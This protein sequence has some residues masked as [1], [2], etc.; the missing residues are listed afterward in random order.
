MYEYGYTMTSDGESRETVL[1]TCTDNEMPMRR[2]E[3][4]YATQHEA[5]QP[6][7]RGQMCAN[8]AQHWV[9]PASK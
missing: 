3:A 5:T 8:P 7:L 9:R 2:R 6:G 1:G 4:E